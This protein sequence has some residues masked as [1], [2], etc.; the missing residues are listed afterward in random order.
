[1][2]L[3]LPPLKDRRYAKK[4]L[5]IFWKENRDNK[6]TPD[7]MTEF[8]RALT[9]LFRFFQLPIPNISWY[10]ELGF[11]G[12]RLGQCTSQGEIQLLTPHYH[13]DDFES[14]LNTVY[15]EIGHYV[16][17]YDEEKKAREFASKM[18]RG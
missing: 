3:A 5:K 16:L 12:T 15:H 9:R 6:F 17:W 11:G 18:R 1:M 14:W 2:K 10:K 7:D 13:G 8:N 4:K